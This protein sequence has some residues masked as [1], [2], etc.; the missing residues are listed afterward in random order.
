MFFYSEACER[1]AIPPS[2]QGM[3]SVAVVE[4]RT[5]TGFFA[6]ELPTEPTCKR[7]PC[8]VAAR[9]CNVATRLQ[10]PLSWTLPQSSAVRVPVTQ[11]MPF[12]ATLTPW[13]NSVVT[14][15]FADL[16]GVHPMFFY[17]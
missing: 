16:V 11:G 3:A 6:T 7:W 10:A 1:T 14:K 13:R 9:T 12:S 4:A 2:E 15:G 8:R 17:N 5:D